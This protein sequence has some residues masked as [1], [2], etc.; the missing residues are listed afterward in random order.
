MLSFLKKRRNKAGND[1]ADQAEAQNAVVFST[2]GS[3]GIQ[4]L[5][6]PQNVSVEQVRTLGVVL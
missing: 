4:T 3:Y 5:A 6:D 1:L 2:A